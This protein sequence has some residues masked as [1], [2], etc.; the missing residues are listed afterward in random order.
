MGKLAKDFAAAILLAKTKRK[1]I[2]DRSQI[3]SWMNERYSPKLE[4]VEDFLKK[5]DIEL[6]HFFTTIQDLADYVKR[7]ADKEGLSVT[8]VFERKEVTN[9]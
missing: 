8:I 7:V 5:N 4:T 3:S 2:G 6:P 1:I 9:D